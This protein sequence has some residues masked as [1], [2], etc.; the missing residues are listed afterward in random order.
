ME[1]AEN[2]RLSIVGQSWFSRVRKAREFTRIRQARFCVRTGNRPEV[3]AVQFRT[4]SIG[5]NSPVFEN[6]RGGGRNAISNNRIFGFVIFR[7]C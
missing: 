7:T 6:P 4:A 1:P 2:L 3:A 5:S